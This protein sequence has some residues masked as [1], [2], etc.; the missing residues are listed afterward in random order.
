MADDVQPG[1][2]EAELGSLSVDQIAAEE[3]RRTQALPRFFRILDTGV[4]TVMVVLLSVL[5]VAVGAN[6]FGR[7][8]LNQSLAWSDELSRFLF[9]WVIF[10]GAA[11]AHLHKEHIAVNVLVERTPRAL[12]RP[13]VIAQELVVLAV[14]LALLVSAREVF[15][16]QPGT[17]ALLGVPLA[18]INISVPF[19]ATFMGLVTLHRIAAVVRRQPAERG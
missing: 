19:C 3:R 11:L 10:L 12:V 5:V 15:A 9:I 16:T 1:T 7:F 17:S 4:K 2:A 13:L 8:V 18:W 6:V 14:V